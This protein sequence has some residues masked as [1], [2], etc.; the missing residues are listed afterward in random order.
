MV[1]RPR[2]GHWSSYALIVGAP[3][4]VWISALLI[5][6]TPTPF[7]VVPSGSMEPNIRRGDLVIVRGT[8]IEKV[9]VGDV[10]VFR[11]PRPGDDRIF[12]HRVVDLVPRDD[13]IYM[14]TKGDGVPVSDSWLVPDALLLRKVV[15]RIPQIGGLKLMIQGRISYIIAAVLVFDLLYFSLPRFARARWHIALGNGG[16]A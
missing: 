8:G 7:L 9:S 6:S 16:A 2:L 5:L 4:I 3:V 14:R 15:A 13:R 12:V 1:S 10:V 11:S